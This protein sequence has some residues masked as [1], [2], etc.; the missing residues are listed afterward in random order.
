MTLHNPGML[1]LL[2]VLVPVI[3]WY[4]W[5]HRGADPTLGVST[6]LPV[7]KLPVSWKVW[8]MHVAF[9]LQCVAIAAM[10]VALARPQ[11]HNSR[12]N[13]RIMG[14]DIVLAL[15]I[16]G[17]MGAKDFS[18]NRF[19][20]AKDVATKFVNNRSN[21]NMGLVT[22]AGESLSL[23]PLTTDR[24]ALVNAIANIQMGDLNDGT[25]IGD[26]LASSINRIAS[27]TAKSKSII[28][29][30]DG[31]N[32]AGD[33]PPATAAQIARQKGI[34]VYTIGVGTNQKIEITDP[35][36]FSSTQ[37]EAKIDEESLKNIAHVT[38]GKYFRAT[39][40]KM[41][42]RVFDEID[43][44]EKTAIDVDRFTQT[45]EN[46]MPWLW[47]AF[48]AF[49]LSMLLRYTILRRIP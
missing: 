13:S 39:D 21:D 35:Y 26:G 30:T 42:K 17:S 4:V 11:T 44:L 43:A 2:L 12:S 7:A 25:A 15:D 47:I 48:G 38:G 10:I 19:E 40:E 1:W 24:P 6:L 31:T 29:L 23:M 34:K 16:S 8:M 32:N 41:L 37:M 33:V 22:F 9:A 20:A 45:E 18:P 14:T 5:K 36:G 49:A 27:G 3:A 46:F 28:L